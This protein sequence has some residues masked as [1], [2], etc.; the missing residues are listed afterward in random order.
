MRTVG[1]GGGDKWRGRARARPPSDGWPQK[2]SLPHVSYSIWR[3][4]DVLQGQGRR[5]CCSGLPD[6]KQGLAGSG[7]KVKKGDI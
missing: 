3:R 4:I 5:R 6:K 2:W 1:G 7:V